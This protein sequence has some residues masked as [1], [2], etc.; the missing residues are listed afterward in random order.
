VQL[1]FCLLLGWNEDLLSHIS[2]M[3]IGTS[4][5][6]SSYCIITVLQSAAGRYADGLKI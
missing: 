2:G 4:L 6:A 3:A 1:M 5:S